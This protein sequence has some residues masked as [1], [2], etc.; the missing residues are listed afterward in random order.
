MTQLN[1]S[2][3]SPQLRPYQLDIAQRAGTILDNHGVVLLT[4]QVRT[5]KT[6]T[7]LHICATRGY[8]K[9]LFVTKKNV[10]DKVKDEFNKFGFVYTIIVTNYESLHNFDGPYDCVIVDEH[11]CVGA[12]PKPSVRA[13]ELRRIVMDAP[14]ILLSGTPTPESFS[15]AFHALWI[16][17]RSPWARFQTFYGWFKEYGVLKYKYLFNRQINDYSGAIPEKVIADL[18]PLSITYTQEQ[19]GF[20]VEVRHHTIE[21]DPPEVIRWTVWK[22]QKDK[23]IT[24][25]DGYTILADTAV[26]EQNKVHQIWSGTIKTEED[27]RIIISDYKAKFIKQRFEGMKVA[28]FYKYIAEGDLLRDVFRGKVA[29]SPMAFNANSD[30]VYISQIVSGREGID[31]S[32][33]DALVMY[34]VDFSALSYLQAPDRINTKDRSAPAPVYWIVAKGGIEIEILEVVRDKQDYTNKHY[35]R[36]CT[37]V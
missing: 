2:V 3:A 12:F 10:V 8:S 23:L 14:V 7:A 9:V 36:T 16:T 11:H 21:I 27:E 22:L 34:N 17:P 35:Q 28:I 13:C 15:Q 29:V 32:T 20:K 30:L 26:K 31:L 4:M 25:R 24:T 19:A 1:N 33:A 5:G 18:E 6:L 37:N